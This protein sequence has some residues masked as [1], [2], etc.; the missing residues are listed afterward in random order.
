MSLAEQEF[1]VGVRLGSL[2]AK[3]V[4]EGAGAHDFEKWV[5]TLDSH[6]PGE[7]GKWNHSK[8][9]AEGLCHQAV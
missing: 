3:L 1:V 5:H 8:R 7:L 4:V 2:A 9:F 6:F